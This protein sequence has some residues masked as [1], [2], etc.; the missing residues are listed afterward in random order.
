MELRLEC[1]IAS[2]EFRSPGRDINPRKKQLCMSSPNKETWRS[3]SWR[4][5]PT[6]YRQREPAA[7]N[8]A[9]LIFTPNGLQDRLVQCTPGTWKRSCASSICS[10]QLPSFQDPLDLERIGWGT[11]IDSALALIADIRL[12]LIDV[13]ALSVC[14]RIVSRPWEAESQTLAARCTS[15]G[16]EDL[17]G[18]PL[19]SRLSGWAFCRR[20]LSTSRSCPLQT[21]GTMEED[22]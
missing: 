6:P 3:Y 15:R 19:S 10:G 14:R 5:D 22:C 4:S 7:F 1:K 16:L 9:I 2:F 18:T 17:D 21:D 8:N 12:P 20:Y 13:W 11:Y